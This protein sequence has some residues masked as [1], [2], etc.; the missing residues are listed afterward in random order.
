[1]HAS[2]LTLAPPARL[3]AKQVTM[4]AT[5]RG[6]STREAI[7]F[8]DERGHG[9]DSGFQCEANVHLTSIYG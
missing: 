6:R 2:G 1:M 3:K 5:A 9:S 4:W 8:E 7:S